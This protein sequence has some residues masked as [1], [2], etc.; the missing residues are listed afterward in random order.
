MLRQLPK[1]KPRPTKLTPRYEGLFKV[2]RQRNN[3]V[4]CRHLVGDFITTLHVS[5]LK[6]F[7]GSHDKAY[8]MA[9]LDNDQFVVKQIVTYRGEPQTRTTMEF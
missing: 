2:I 1:D 4:E 9:L 6:R 3:D 5:R 8:K 7:H